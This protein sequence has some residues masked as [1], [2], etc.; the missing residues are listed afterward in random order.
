MTWR[1]LLVVVAALCTISIAAAQEKS[2]PFPP[3]ALLNRITP[4]GIRANME[5]SRR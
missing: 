1:R 4:A 2:L 5:I 3:A